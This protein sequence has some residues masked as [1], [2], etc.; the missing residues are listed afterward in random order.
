MRAALLAGVLATLALTSCV[1]LTTKSVSFQRTYRVPNKVTDP[2]RPDAR[3]AVL[4]VGHATVLLQLDD[5]QI[6]TDPVFTDTVGEVS[7]RFVEPG[8]DPARLP[9]LDAVLLSHVHM[10]HLSYGS[11]DRIARKTR[12]LVAPAGARVYV[13]DSAVPLAELATW[14]RWER[15]G[16]VVTA[17]PVRHVGW[18][19]G[20]DA[21]WMTRTFT[22]YVIEYHGLCVYFGGDTAYVEANFKQTAARFPKIDLALLPIAPIRPRSFMRRTHVDPFEAAR[23]FLDLGARRMMPIHFDTFLNGLDEQ[24]DAPRELLRAKDALRLTDE[25]VIVLRIGEQRVIVPRDAGTVI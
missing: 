13:P 23:A 2:V 1:R 6:L 4:W 17:V 14:S 21:A 3:I 25:Q 24:G 8:L 16:L 18:R 12:Q 11:L 9:V 19:Y 10:D 5:K 15:D 22:G 7:D 20:V